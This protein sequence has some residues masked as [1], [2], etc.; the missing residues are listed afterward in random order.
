MQV[1]KLH[2]VIGVYDPNHYDSWSWHCQYEYGHYLSLKHRI[3][4]RERAAEF[5]T[6]K[7]A[8]DFLF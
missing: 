3:C 6:E 5:S 7:E 1:L 2:Y 4:G 8:T